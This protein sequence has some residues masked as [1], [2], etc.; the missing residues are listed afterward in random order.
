MVMDNERWHD[1]PDG[2]GAGRDGNNV[3]RENY[4]NRDDRERYGRPSGERM[5][6][7]RYVREGS[8]ERP[9]RPRINRNAERPYGNREQGERAYR[10][11]RPYN[12]RGDE[13]GYRSFNR[14]ERPNFSRPYN[15]DGGERPWAQS[16][17]NY[18]GGEY[19]RD[20]N[21]RPRINQ[22]GNRP[23]PGQRDGYNPNAKYSK[24][25]QIEYK[26]QFVD[27]NEP[28][29]LNKF[30]A[31][32][33]ICSRREAD[34]Y[35]TAGV[36]SVNGEVVKELGTKVKRSDLVRFHDQPV[37]IERKVHRAQGV[38]AAEQAERLRHY[39]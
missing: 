13:R 38:C 23:R 34:E 19:Y 1:G 29:R 7:P 4:Y 15:R 21:R 22:G 33:G 36:V 30:L 24:K 25:K 10:P 26:E 11:S 2:Q 31:N 5:Q 12:N 35:I 28:I 9:Q 27:P 20:G 32:A 17:P 37:S 16:R 14:E 6:R 8:S 39:L 3:N 18:G